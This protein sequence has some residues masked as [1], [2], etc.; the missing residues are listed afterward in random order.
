METENNPD[1]TLELRAFVNQKMADTE[2]EHVENQLK[3][4]VK[5]LE[6]SNHAL[7]DFTA[8][9]SHDLQA[10]LGR[11]IMLGDRLANHC[12]NLLDEQG[13]DYLARMQK[14]TLR[15]QELI[16]G[17]LEYS[18]VIAKAGEFEQVDFKIIVSEVIE[19]LEAE[20]NLT[21]AE[22][23]VSELPAIEADKLQIRQLFQNLISN[24]LKFCKDDAPPVI[25]I[26]SSSFAKGCEE[27]TVE[28]NGIGFDMKYLGHI[29][30]PFTR[31]FTNNY[32]GNGIGLAICQKIVAR[33]EGMI[34]AKSA[35][36]KGTKFSIILPDRQR[37]R[38][39]AD[40]VVP[41]ESVAEADLR[42]RCWTDLRT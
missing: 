37:N 36:D 3:K 20:I 16:R 14:C 4:H 40:E 32:P 7:S 19:D 11:L 39:E 5:K 1:A 18:K 6:K 33:H 15:M 2:H 21:K 10:P 35:P 25:K 12:N 31:L 29:F 27:I 42:K 23:Q 17:L 22:I 8:A 34:T 28:D 26:S 24:A 30:K 38:S 9:V 13:K 41:E